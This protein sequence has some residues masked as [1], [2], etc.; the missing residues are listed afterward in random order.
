MKYI[1]EFEDEP[2]INRNGTKMYRI[3]GSTSV[4]VPS[5]Y[6]NH[7]PKYEENPTANDDE[8]MKELKTL[9]P[10]DII[11][12][13]NY[14]L[15]CGIERQLVLFRYEDGPK[16]QIISQITGVILVA[17]ADELRDSNWRK[18]CSSYDT[19]DFFYSLRKNG[20]DSNEE[21]SAEELSDLQPGDIICRY[22]SV[23]RPIRQMVNF[24]YTCPPSYELINEGGWKRKYYPED[25][26]KHGYHKFKGELTTK[27]FYWRL[28]EEERPDVE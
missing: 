1:I 22:D 24:V 7:F 21:L 26:I 16:Y 20:S 15:S 9:Q 27:D 19:K 13:E 5:S 3:K 11:I 28:R 23:G 14:L 4:F 6:L 2:F 25:L 17:S 10:G 12:R 8:R 18:Y